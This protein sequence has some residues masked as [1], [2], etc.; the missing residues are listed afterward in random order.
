MT[1]H[2]WI[3]V[4]ATSLVFLYCWPALTLVLLFSSAAII[5]SCILAFIL[6]ANRYYD[7]MNR[8]YS[9][10]FD[11]YR[12]RPYLPELFQKNVSKSSKFSG[13]SITGSAKLDKILD[14][15][16]DVLI[17]D[18]ITVW[19]SK[20]TSDRRF[21]NS[22]KRIASR[23]LRTLCER[24]RRLD[25]VSLC[26][27]HFVDDFACHVRLYR[28]S[29][30]KQIK[31]QRMYK[32]SGKKPDDL[33]TIFFDMEFQME[34]QHICRDLIVCSP[35][36][37]R[38]CL[39]DIVDLLLYLLLPSEDFRCRP[40]HFLIREILISKVFI[41]LLNLLSD[42][43][44]LNHLL[45]WLLSN[46]ATLLSDDFISILQTCESIQDLEA[47]LEALKDE[48]NILH[49]KDQSGSIQNEI[50][51]LQQ[52]FYV[53]TNLP[54]NTIKLS[55]TLILTN[56]IALS[57]FS[58]FLASNGQQSYLDLY[59]AIEGF[60]NSVNN[61]I[62][63]RAGKNV[64]SDCQ[65]TIKEA[66]K[67]IYH[68]FLATNAVTKVPISEDLVNKFLVRMNSD[69]PVDSWFDSIQKQITGQLENDRNLY[70]AFLRDPSYR[71]L[72]EELGI[73]D[74]NSDLS[75]ITESMPSK[76]KHAKMYITIEMLG[77]GGQAKDQNNLFAV[78]NVRV[79]FA[80]DNGDIT[81]TWNVIRRYSDFYKLNTT[82]Q[83][84]FP[85]LQSIEFP[86]KKTFNNLKQRF[87]E[88]RCKALNN[89]MTS[90]TDPLNL[91]LNPGLSELVDAFLSQQKYIGISEPLPK[92]I[93]SAV[94]DPIFTGVK[95][96][97]TAAIQMP[98]QMFKMGLEI[99]KAAVNVI[100]TATN[101]KPPALDFRR[102]AV[103]ASL[104]LESD[105]A[106]L[107]LRVLILLV[108]EF[109][110]LQSRNQ[111]FRANI[112]AALRNFLHLTYG[113]SLNKKIISF[114]KWMTSENQL[115]TYLCTLRGWPPI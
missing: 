104:D 101:T 111:W 96:V 93:A 32:Q 27:R 19:Y 73:V 20:L 5:S 66:A 99:N 7:T 63:M 34:Q 54:V 65:E 13:D 28:L 48:V 88:Q 106:S 108:D 8:K 59:M 89:Y 49:S 109:F 76:I 85:R 83:Q 114:V 41:P 84:K 45:V 11:D 38:A 81:K 82:I 15:I 36:Y 62:R 51:M 14:E 68:Q 6:Y 23:T 2:N 67:F 95:A 4:A 46:H 79:Q 39:H 87:L 92:K 44:Y 110:G 17:Q 35:A 94:F 70:P 42:P 30:E 50:Q 25:F 9:N 115:A 107:P 18:F 113:Y 57:H 100:R 37:E 61:Q 56:S 75:A 33:E 52:A 77:V 90:I 71:Q 53:D 12:F 16:F 78:Y 58:R 69:S 74:E 98:D 21:P 29:K 55:M 91:K 26:T 3:L 105:D 22:L 102:V 10:V 103:S 43:D 47:I 112:V 31:Q 40:L 72:L 80:N 1:R 64:D 86:G 24:L 97:G 60:K